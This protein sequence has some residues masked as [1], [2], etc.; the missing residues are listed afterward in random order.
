MGR[1]KMRLLLA[2]ICTAGLAL[3][4]GEKPGDFD[5]YVLAL[6]WSPNWCAIEG[7]AKGSDQCDAR[8]DHGWGHAAAG[9]GHDSAPKAIIRPFAIQAPSQ[10]AAV[11]VQLVPTDVEPFFVRKAVSHA[12]SPGSGAAQVRLAQWPRYGQRWVSG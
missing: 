4:D 9:D 6:S 3:A 10:R 2:W 1:D 7:D 11:T 8:H 12:I 5:Y